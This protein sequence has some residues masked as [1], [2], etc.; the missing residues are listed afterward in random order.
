MATTETLSPFAPHD[1]SGY[2]SFQEDSPPGLTASGSSDDGSSPSSIADGRTGHRAGSATSSH[3]SS[4]AAGAQPHCPPSVLSSS[5]KADSTATSIG[6]LSVYDAAM[7]DMDWNSPPFAHAAAAGGPPSDQSSFSPAAFFDAAGHH[8]H[9][10]LSMHHFNM[11]SPS[12]SSP[13]IAAPDD[14]EA[15]RELRAAS[16]RMAAGNANGTSGSGP[17]ADHQ[18]RANHTNANDNDEQMFD[19]IIEESSF[20]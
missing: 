17:G 2:A 14:A 9:T 8:A 20:G 3:S 11:A 19:S 18:A 10:D 16:Q 13:G 7:S 6:A 15:K 12:L 4:A 1:S 5:S